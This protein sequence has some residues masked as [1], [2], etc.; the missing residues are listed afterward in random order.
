ME[1]V[2]FLSI[3]KILHGK[4]KNHRSDKFLTTKSDS[5]LTARKFL[6]LFYQFTGNINH[7]IVLITEKKIEL[8]QIIN[9][10]NYTEDITCN[11]KKLT[12]GIKD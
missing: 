5:I 11:G 1:L 12:T 6:L 3:D 8:L 9:K 4:K 7:L 10:S 2:K